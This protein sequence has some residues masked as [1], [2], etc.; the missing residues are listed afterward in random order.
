MLGS[1]FV[2]PARL[3]KCVWVGGNGA[4]FSSNDDLNI[5]TKKKRALNEYEV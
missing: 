4:G 2:G 1:Q 3:G 5:L